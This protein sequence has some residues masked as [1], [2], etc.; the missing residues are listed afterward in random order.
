[1]DVCVSV[2]A[3]VAGLVSSM[4]RRSRILS[5]VA[6]RSWLLGKPVTGTQKRPQK[7][8]ARCKEVTRTQ[9]VFAKLSSVLPRVVPHSTGQA[10]TVGRNVF[11]CLILKQK[12]FP[13]LEC[14]VVD[15]SLPVTPWYSEQQSEQTPFGG[16]LL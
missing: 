4:R 10:S 5:R 11:F 9:N 12:T 2:A 1:M 16:H 8:K 15:S 14:S 6:L 13:G 7:E 3:L